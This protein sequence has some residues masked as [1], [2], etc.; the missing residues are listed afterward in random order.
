VRIADTST[1]V[2]IFKLFEHCG[3]GIM[4]SLG[5]MGIPV[6]GIDPDP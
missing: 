6:Y 5:R 1:P 4:R 2:V 3:A